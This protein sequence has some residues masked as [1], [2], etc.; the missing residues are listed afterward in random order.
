MDDDPREVVFPS[1]EGECVSVPQSAEGYGGEAVA[2]RERVGSG[3][4]QCA[5]RVLVCR[6]V[7]NERALTDLP[8]PQERDGAALGKRF[9]NLWADVACKEIFQHL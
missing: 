2:E 7:C 1:F 5:G 9:E 6:D 3:I 4:D 8:G